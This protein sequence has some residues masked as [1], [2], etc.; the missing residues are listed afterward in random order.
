M[1]RRLAVVSIVALFLVSACGSD[2]PASPQEPTPLPCAEPADPAPDLT[3]MNLEGQDISIHGQR[4]QKVLLLDFWA[5]WCGPCREGL[6]LLQELHDTYADQG[7]L[8]LAVNLAEDPDAVRAF[9][10]DAGY[11]F[12]VLLDPGDLARTEYEVTSIPR[13]IIVDA[14]GEVRFD[15]TG[16]YGIEDLD[17][18]AII[19]ALLAELEP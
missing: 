17:H 7:L 10:A 14:A 2:D 8:V 6:P 15:R 19:P 3:L 12:P 5:M 9:M 11:T 13:Q 16:L 1:V 18:H 4:C